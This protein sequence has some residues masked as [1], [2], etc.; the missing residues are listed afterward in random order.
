MG[1]A[2]NSGYAAFSSIVLCL[3]VSYNTRV[4]VS[5]TV[6]IYVYIYMYIYK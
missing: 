2:L 1:Q 3:E 4:S 5:S 6:C